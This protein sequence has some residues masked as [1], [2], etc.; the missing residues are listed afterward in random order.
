MYELGRLCVKIAG[1]DSRK[2]A[3]VIDILDKNFVLIDGETRR[4]KCNL[5]H[6]EPLNTVYKIKK[7]A[8][9]KEII[10]LFKR[11]LNIEIV[12]KKAKTKSEKPNKIRKSSR[13]EKESGE[14]ASVQK[15]TEK[16]SKKKN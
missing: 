14:T 15:K 1:R 12:E 8:S 4:R 3:L 13:Q 6:L 10:E 16:K 2:K 7:N 9:H 11:E 5:K